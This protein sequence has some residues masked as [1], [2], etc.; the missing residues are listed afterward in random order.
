MITIKTTH[1]IK[2]SHNYNK[3]LEILSFTT[4]EETVLNRICIGH[5]RLTH[6]YSIA[7]EEALFLKNRRT[8]YNERQR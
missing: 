2:W 5:T 7:E 6:A 3:Q 4:E 1:L 8:N